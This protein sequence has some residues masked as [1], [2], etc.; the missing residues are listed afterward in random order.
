L[1]AQALF[2]DAA[3]SSKMARM[4]D[5]AGKTSIFDHGKV[6]NAKRWF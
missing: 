3:M 2:A 1:E 4:M 6:R 5:R